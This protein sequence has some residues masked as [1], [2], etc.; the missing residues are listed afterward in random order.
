LIWGSTYLGIRFAVETL[1]PF[2]MGGVRYGLAG[3]ILYGWLRLHG[4]PRPNAGHW[5]SA[6]IAGALML[7]GG[8]GL[9]NFAQQS[10][11]SGL[12]A[13]VV[14]TVPIWFVTIAWLGPDREAPNSWEIGSII[15]GVSGVG[16]LMSGS[17]EDMGIGEAGGREVLIGIGALVIATIT[18]SAGSIFS[19]RAQRA[20]PTLLSTAM[21]M[22]GGGA[23]LVIAGV[24]LGEFGRFDPAAVSTRSLIALAYLIVFGSIIAFSCFVWLFQVV[25]PALAGTYAYVNPIVAVFLGWAL[26]D[27]AV[28]REMAFGA[29]LIIGAVVLV[30]RGRARA[31]RQAGGPTDTARP[32]QAVSSKNGVD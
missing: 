28:T 1:P 31:R 16:L 22:I 27:E 2:L 17:L 18:W 6:T 30:E 4:A 8:N 32:G 5:R 21:M 23:L 24:L 3:L 15:L 7:L 14:G 13:L 19:R 20:K 11:P 10:V 26:A 25:R 9:V 29:V 12:T